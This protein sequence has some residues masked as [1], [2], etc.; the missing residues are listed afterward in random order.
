VTIFIT[1]IGGFLGSWLASGLSRRGHQV[2]GSIHRWQERAG[3]GTVRL[4]LDEPF[5]PA[6]FAGC[7]AIVH[8]AHDF[9][10]GAYGK[11]VSGTT[12]WATAAAQAGAARQLFI[13]SPSAQAQSP[14]EYGRVK[15]A[16][17]RWFIDRG[18]LVVRP[19]LVIGPGG[20]FAR[21]RAAL[22]RTPIVPLIGGGDQPTLVIGIDHL[23]EAVA[24][25][26]ESG[27]PRESSL[28]YDDCPPIRTLVTAVKAAAG[29]RAI[30]VTI[31]PS[32]AIG[33]TWLA[34]ALRVPVPVT[35]DQIRT[36]LHAR[37]NAVPSD[38]RRLL[39]DR[40]AEFSLAHALAAAAQRSV[41][42]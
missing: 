5:D 36:L 12:A 28:F 15:H 16:L 20:L 37:P 40:T 39:P 41:V 8:G 38:L 2:K 34:S 3:A 18:H 19:G 10:R 42:S 22:L 21:Q 13:S 6:V 33:L 35:P 7:D 30:V 26:L 23:V 9:T 17:E 32:I 14:S 11:N 1:A 27:A 31:P 24:R 4:A 25:I 29:Q